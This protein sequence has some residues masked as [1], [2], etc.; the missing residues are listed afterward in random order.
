MSWNSSPQTAR[1]HSNLYKR[2]RPRQLLEDLRAMSGDKDLSGAEYLQQ[3]LGDVLAKALSSVAQERPDDPVQFVAEYLY[4]VCLVQLVG[5]SKAERD[6]VDTK[7]LE[8]HVE[9][10]YYEFFNPD[11]CKKDVIRNRIPQKSNWSWPTT[12]CICSHGCF[13][14]LPPGRSGAQGAAFG[15]V[16]A[17]VRP[18]ERRRPRQRPLRRPGGARKQRHRHHH[19][20]RQGQGRRQDRRRR[21]TAGGRGVRAQVHYNGMDN[22]VKSSLTLVM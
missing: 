9:N 6:D 15:L 7:L 13:C 10:G 17:H 14:L 1:F 11:T 4:K 19:R 2:H 16:P 12:V 3:V 22:Q 20:C 21:R 8:K 5:L 18:A